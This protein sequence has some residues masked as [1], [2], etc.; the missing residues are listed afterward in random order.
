M[1]CSDGLAGLDHGLL[2]L[3]YFHS[4]LFYPSDDFM[5]QIVC[6]NSVEPLY[7]KCNVLRWLMLGK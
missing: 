5:I 3:V 4:G 6:S 2:H 1:T 7:L